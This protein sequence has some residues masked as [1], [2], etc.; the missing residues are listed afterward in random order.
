MRKTKT[1]VRTIASTSH[2]ARYD[3]FGSTAN[4]RA[5]FSPSCFGTVPGALA[6]SPKTS[7]PESLARRV[8]QRFCEARSAFTDVSISTPPTAGLSAVESFLPNE[9]PVGRAPFP[10]S[11]HAGVPTWREL[12]R[13]PSASMCFTSSRSALSSRLSTS[14]S[15]SRVDTSSPPMADAQGG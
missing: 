1:R 7:D 4:R 12:G 13:A 11:F 10:R 9:T 2:T 8:S 6:R 5:G 14:P 3:E 15:A